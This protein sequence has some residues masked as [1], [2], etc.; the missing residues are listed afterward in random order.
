MYSC[1]FSCKVTSRVRQTTAWCTKVTNQRDYIS[2]E[3]FN[4]NYNKYRYDSFIFGS[5]RT[6]AFSPSSWHRYIGVNAS[7]FMFDASNETITGILGKLNYLD[8]QGV[9]IKNTLIILCLDCSFRGAESSTGHLFIK[10]P[11]TSKESRLDFQVEFLRAYFNVKFL[12]K[13]FAFKLIGTYRPFMAGVIEPR[14]ITYDRVTNE[15]RIHDQE[16]ELL[17][18]PAEYYSKRKQIFYTRT[19]EHSDT[20]TR[21]DAAQISVLLKIKQILEKQHTEYRIVISPLYDQIRCSDQDLRVLKHLFGSLVYNFS[22]RNRF[23]ESER[24]Y[25]E[26]S[27]YRPQVGD[28]IM[29]S[30]YMN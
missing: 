21:I 11:A 30:I 2:T 4:R 14:R 3:M 27:H 10:H 23:T 1:L 12:Y 9:K 19:E 6:L 17:Q 29:D 15:V 20:V 25:Y 16:E 22:G 24:N 13:F 5:S 26:A 28:A 7:P 8:S 18:S